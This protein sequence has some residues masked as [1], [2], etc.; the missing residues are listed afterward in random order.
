MRS[1]S[2]FLPENVR[3]FQ[4]CLLTGLSFLRCIHSFGSFVKAQLTIFTWVC[5]VPLTHV[6]VCSFTNTSLPCYCFLG[7]LEVGQ[8]LELQRC[9][10]SIMLAVAGP[11]LLHVNSRIRT[12]EMTCFSLHCDSMKLKNQHL[13]NTGSSSP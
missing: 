8:L 11:V 7:G 2:R 4:H 9:S 6:S 12:H 13:D 1:V 10:P 3:L 5:C